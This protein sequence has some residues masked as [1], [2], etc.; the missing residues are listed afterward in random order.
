MVPGYSGRMSGIILPVPAQAMPEPIVIAKPG[1]AIVKKV[2]QPRKVET[3][4]LQPIIHYVVNENPVPPVIVLTVI[5]KVEVP[6]S[7]NRQ[8][9]REALREQIF[10]SAIGFIS[11]LALVGISALVVNWVR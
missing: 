9:Y 8:I 7:V 10:A 3:K 4:V 2:L 6:V 5:E 11:A 1:K